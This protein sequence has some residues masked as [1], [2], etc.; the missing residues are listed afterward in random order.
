M[1]IDAHAHLDKYGAELQAV[2]EEIERNGIFTWTVSMDLP[3]YQRN[4][5]VAAMSKMVLP[6]FGIHPRRAP[7]YAGRLADLNPWIE[8]SPAIGEIGL[9]F[10]WIKE[11]AHY[12]A[13]RK[14]FEYFLAA[15]REQKKI[16]NLHTKGAEKDI[17]ALL[18]RYDLARA[19]VHWYSGPLD[20]LNALVDH[21]AYFTVGVEILKSEKIRQIARAVPL[22]QILTETDN[23]RGLQ[24]LNGTAGMPAIVLDVVEE[25]AALKQ[26]TPEAVAQAVEENF[27]RLIDGDAQIAKFI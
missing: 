22:W 19:V 16:V 17:L 13:Q 20:I 4:L 21:G 1:L 26:T 14:V 15:A 10:H 3:S 6:T 12:P 5:E 24:W 9:D 25:I 23:P 11:R 7:E 8:R 27:R 2:L 18:G